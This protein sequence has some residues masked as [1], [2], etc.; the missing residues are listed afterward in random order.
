MPGN[1]GKVWE[2]TTSLLNDTDFPKLPL[3]IKTYGNINLWEY[4][5]KTI[6]SINQSINQSKTLFKCQCRLAGVKKLLLIWGHSKR[7]LEKMTT[8]WNPHL[9]NLAIL[10]ESRWLAKTKSELNKLM[11]FKRLSVYFPTS[12]FSACNE[13]FSFF[14]RCKT[15]S[16]KYRNQ[17]GLASFLLLLGCSCFVRS[18]HSLGKSDLHNTDL[19]LKVRALFHKV[20]SS[21]AL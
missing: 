5:L 11:P 8:T 10:S 13:F 3:T 15:S 18:D 4:K 12:W 19:G 20:D 7:I 21:L 14:V 17:I 6:Q 16:V 1:E 9:C 2:S